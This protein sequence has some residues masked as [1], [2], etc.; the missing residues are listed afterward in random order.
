MKKKYY[1]YKLTDI[2]TNEFYI[3]SR[4]FLGEISKDKYMGSPKT[5]KPNYV[6]V[7]KEIID[8]FENQKDAILFEREL[9][10]N[11]INDK[12]NMNFSI[13]HP[14]ITRE[15]LISAKDESG[16]VITISTDDPLFGVK[17][18]GITKGL[19]LVKDIDGNVF[20]TDVNDPRYVNG[21]LVHNNKGLISKDSHPNFNKVWVNNGI[22]QKLIPINED[23]IGWGLGTLQ[24]GKKTLSS[25]DNSIWIHHLVKK[26]T[27]RISETELNHYLNNGWVRGR[28]KLGNYK[29]NN[30]VKNVVIPNFKNYRWVSN[31]TENINKRVDVDKLDEFLFNGWEL[32]RLK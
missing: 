23:Y 20:L 4:G 17:Y 15:N 14:N 27:K 30:K 12:L 9:I 11:K 6:K 28:L 1:V 25:H 13:P 10:I 16:K 3:G 2:K 8:I 32:G 18:F 5:W 26:E 31:K 24:K 7:K 22:E 19:V 21:D 29:K